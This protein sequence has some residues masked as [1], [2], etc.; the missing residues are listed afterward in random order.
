M[1]DPYQ[2]SVNCYWCALKDRNAGIEPVGIRAVCKGKGP[3]EGK[4][5]CQPHGDL[6]LISGWYGGLLPK[7]DEATAILLDA[8]DAPN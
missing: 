3:F 8:Y 2:G 1:S 4:F 5:A 6:L 7:P